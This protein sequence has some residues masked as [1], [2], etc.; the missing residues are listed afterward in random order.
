MEILS[1][2][3]QDTKKMAGSIA[4]KLKPFDVIALYGDLGAGKTTFSSYLVEALG[5]GSRVQSPTF[6]IARRYT[7]EKGIIKTINHIDL[8]RL[9][10]VAELHEIDLKGLLQEKDALTLIEWPE[11]AQ[12]LLPESTINIRFELIDENTRSINVQNLH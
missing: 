7:H 8:Y 5:F 4:A 3:T 2:T 6:V 11:I 9:R 12:E 1:K 10:S